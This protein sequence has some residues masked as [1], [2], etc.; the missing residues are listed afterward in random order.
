MAYCGRNWRKAALSKT[1]SAAVLRASIRPIKSKFTQQG[2]APRRRQS[3]R[4]ALGRTRYKVGGEVRF[5]VTDS[6][7]SAHTRVTDNSL[8][9]KVHIVLAPVC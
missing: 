8:A 1:S 6:I 3:V 4:E 5:P 7:K 2:L 9:A